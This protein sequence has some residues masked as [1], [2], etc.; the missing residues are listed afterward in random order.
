MNSSIASYPGPKSQ[1]M[2]FLPSFGKMSSCSVWVLQNIL[3]HYF[4]FLLATVFASVTLFWGNISSFASST[5]VLWHHRGTEVHYHFG[6]INWPTSVSCQCIICGAN[7]TS[8]WWM[9]LH[10]LLNMT[11]AGSLSGTGMPDKNQSEQINSPNVRHLVI[12]YSNLQF[13]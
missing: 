13:G 9:D 5:S 8:Q 3:I 4:S 2:M 11:P 6:W 10:A 12:L 1:I 7:C